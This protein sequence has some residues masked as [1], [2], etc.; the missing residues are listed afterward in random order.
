MFS[1]SKCFQK[2]VQHSDETCPSIKNKITV[3]RKCSS[4][5]HVTFTNR[6]KLR[7]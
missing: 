2:E 6:L 4:T 5:E 1:A 7:K 3:F